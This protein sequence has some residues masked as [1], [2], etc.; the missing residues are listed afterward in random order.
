[1]IDH[2]LSWEVA[3][4][5]GLIA[6]VLV[7]ASVALGL[8][9][10]LSVR[11]ARWPRFI[12]AEL[13][14]FVTV[15]AL[16]FLLVHGIAVLVDPFTGFTP[17]EVLVPFASHYRPLWVAT[18]IVSG[19]LAI[20]VWASEYVRKRIGY[21][22][23]RRLHYLS[24][25]AFLL[26]A[27]HGLGTGSDSASWWGL[28]LYAI[29][30]GMVAVLVAWRLVRAFGTGSRALSLAV[31]GAAMAAL[32]IFTAVGPAQ[33]GWN[34]IANNGHGS[35]ASAA[36]LA[37]HTAG[38]AGVPGAFT[39]RFDGSLVADDRL[40]GRFTSQ[41][42]SGTLELVVGEDGGVLS[43]AFDTGWACSG[44]V[45]FGGGDELEASCE[46]TDGTALDVVL[47]D[48]RRSETGVAGQLRVRP[49]A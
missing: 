1:M 12:T 34:E 47:G 2:T 46:R 30:L 45:R 26:G 37:Q 17:A 38:D 31:V 32:V 27:L 18:G 44:Q 35:G 15:L 5:G 3:R 19:Y 24:F 8:L 11:S 36:W 39:A 10:S 48:L 22:W 29:T 33:A 40:A 14:R 20:A 9:L 21:G 25:A 42:G 23:W 43:L 6:Y 28:A 13:H 16:V 7:T 49:A 41:D 4:V